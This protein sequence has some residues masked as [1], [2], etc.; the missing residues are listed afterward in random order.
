MLV[1][2]ILFPGIGTMVGGCMN[3]GGCSCCIVT[4]G[5][6]Q[7]FTTLLVFGYFWGIVSGVLA[8]VYARK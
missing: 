2:N 7:M 4:I 6:V 8:I 5:I 3:H 1:L